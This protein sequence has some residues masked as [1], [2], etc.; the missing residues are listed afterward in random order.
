MLISAAILGYG[1]VGKAVVKRLQA[2]EGYGEDFRIHTIYVPDMSR[3]PEMQQNDD[4]QWKLKDEWWGTENPTAVGDDLEWLIQ[5]DGHDTVIDCAPYTDESRDLI[6]KLISKGY[7]LH[8]CSKGLVQREWKELIDAGNE[9]GSMII[10]NSIPAGNPNRYDNIDL[11]NDTFPQY[12]DEPDMFIFRDGGPEEVAD[13]I[14]KDV[15]TELNRR[16][17][18]KAKYDAL[19]EEGKAILDA[20]GNPWEDVSS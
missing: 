3:Y 20:G 18:I 11:N 10:L 6:Y 16:R 2:L 1:A 17:H 15:E 5:S 4:F 14:V 12:A 7:W 8:T 13:K 9:S 19:S